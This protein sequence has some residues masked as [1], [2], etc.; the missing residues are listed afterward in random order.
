MIATIDKAGRLVIPKDLRE[1][2]G[3]TPGPVE[4]TQ[5]GAAVRIEPLTS[6]GAVERRGRLVIDDN[7]ALD[8][9]KV[10]SLRLGDQR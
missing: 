3:L 8:D 10:R 9:Q 5:D 4:L 7:V 2:L 6:H 1:A